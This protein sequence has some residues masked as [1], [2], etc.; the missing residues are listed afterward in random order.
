MRLLLK[1]FL[2][3]LVVAPIA[4]V[5]LAFQPNPTLP[6]QATLT[7]SQ[8]AQSKSLILEARAAALGQGNGQIKV[9]EAQLRGLIASAARVVQPLRGRAIIDAGGIQLDFAGQV[10]HFG[11]LGWVNLSMTFAPSTDQLEVT[12]L[13]VGNMGLPPALTT[14][15]AVTSLDWLSGEDLGSLLVSS[16]ERLETGN[17]VALITLK[18]HGDG[19]DSLFSRVVDGIRSVTGLN[20]NAAIEDF[21]GLLAQAATS[22]ELPNR[23]DFTPWAIF[24]LSH[25]GEDQAKL[26]PALL[27]L[28]AH[29]G[30]TR[31]VMTMAGNLDLPANSPC[32]GTVLAGRSDL[33][34]HFTL[35]AAFQAA[36]G[37]TI[38]F[39][40][41][42]VKE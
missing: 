15:I 22:G 19:S 36:G 35:S 39:G 2:L 13:R 24:T 31:A 4:F 7:A 42:E 21:Y 26:R 17:G 23:G 27:A 10:P 37:S 8:A 38:S 32:R 5:V 6:D 9:S 29:C 25:I 3:L 18:D 33:R 40:L 1:L 14:R 30:S 16:I 34:Q 41:G 20:D 28:A 11:Q 12:S